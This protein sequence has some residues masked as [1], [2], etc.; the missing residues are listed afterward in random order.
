[1]IEILQQMQRYKPS[2]ISPEQFSEWKHD[3]VTETLFAVLMAAL[4]DQLDEDLPE[5]TI[6]RRLMVASE[7]EGA[8]KMLQTLIDWN[9]AGEDDDQTTG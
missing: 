4:I 5:D 2:P 3:P 6:D 1:M 9:P 8:R 7:R